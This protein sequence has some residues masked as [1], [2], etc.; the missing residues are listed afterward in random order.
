MVNCNRNSL[1]RKINST[2]KTLI[3]FDSRQVVIVVKNTNSDQDLKKYKKNL[4]HSFSTITFKN[5]YKNSNKFKIYLRLIL[6]L[7]DIRT[8]NYY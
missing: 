3:C 7:F 5:I 2:F 6:Q 4:I 8:L 1:K